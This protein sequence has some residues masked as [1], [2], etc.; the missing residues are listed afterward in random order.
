MNPL[1]RRV[2][3]TER[4]ARARAAFA[5][6]GEGWTAGMSA[7]LP[8]V[9][10]HPR[11][12][13]LRASFADEASWEDRLDWMEDLAAVCGDRLLRVKCFIRRPGSDVPLLV[14]AVG[15]LFGPP[16]PMPGARDV[17]EG[18]V[19]IVGDLDMAELRAAL[20]DA[21]VRLAAVRGGASLACTSA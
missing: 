14:Q 15:T 8:P 5:D 16:S 21:P 19:V 10:V 4:A 2:V 17:E 13:V 9:A 12:S 1:A 7:V 6:S 3:E 20:P 18:L 11:V